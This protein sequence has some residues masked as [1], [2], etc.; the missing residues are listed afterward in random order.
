MDDN[1]TH[2][3]HRAILH[4]TWFRTLGWWNN[5]I[6]L[7]RRVRSNYCIVFHQT[8]IFLITRNKKSYE[9]SLDVIV[10]AFHRLQCIFEI[11]IEIKVDDH[12]NNPFD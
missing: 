3:S 2:S 12:S 1:T 5:L 8:K 9:L 6:D 4:L 7:I 11:F 10:A